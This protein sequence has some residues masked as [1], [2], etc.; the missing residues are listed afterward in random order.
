MSIQNGELKKKLF[1]FFY[2]SML[3]MDTITRQMI[4]S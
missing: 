4:M 1:F 3:L 2:N